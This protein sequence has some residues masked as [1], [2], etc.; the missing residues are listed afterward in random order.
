YRQREMLRIA[1][2]DLSRR[3]PLPTLVREL[4]HLADALVNAALSF[5]NRRLSPRFGE[6]LLSHFCVLALGK[7]GGR[8]LN[9][10][11]D[12]D[13]IFVYDENARTPSGASR[14]EQAV[15]VAEGLM[16]ALSEVTEDGFAFR[17][18]A[19]L[20]PEG[21]AGPLAHSLP[22]LELYYERAG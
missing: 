14:R 21:R 3:A 17:V 11:S 10:S 12:I 6:S 20:R 18:D 13:V 7:H 1:L 2:R 22:E 4:S 16:R 15:K 8:E 9:Y 19:N 5:V